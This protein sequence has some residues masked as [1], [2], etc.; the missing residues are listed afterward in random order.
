MSYVD[1]TPQRLSLALLLIAV[2]LVL[3]RRGRLDLTG[4]LLLGAVRG[5]AQLIAIG[6]VL[7]LLFDHERPLWVLLLLS[8]MIVV[9]A[10]TAARRVE[11]GP[12]RRVRRLH[13]TIIAGWFCSSHG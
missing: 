12:P 9:A 10:A 2:A 6:Y 4:D 13:Q 5:A 7:L 11:H 8:V 1:I 3:S